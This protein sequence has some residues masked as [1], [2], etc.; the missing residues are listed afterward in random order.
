LIGGAPS[1]AAFDVAAECL[2]EPALRADAELTML[3]CGENIVQRVGKAIA[4][5]VEK[6]LSSSNPKVRERAQ[7]LLTNIKRL[8]EKQ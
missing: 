6:L 8:E 7:W 3:T 1:K 2:A 5:D 4:P